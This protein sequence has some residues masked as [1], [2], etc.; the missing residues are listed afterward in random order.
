MLPN[1]TYETLSSSAV[2]V[3]SAKVTLWPAEAFDCALCS[4]SAA[5][6]LEEAAMRSQ[7][8]SM[9]A[10]RRATST[11]SPAFEHSPE[12][13]STPAASSCQWLNAPLCQ[14]PT[15]RRVVLAGSETEMVSIRPER[16]RAHTPPRLTSTFATFPPTQSW[17]NVQTSVTARARRG[18]QRIAT[19]SEG[20]EGMS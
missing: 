12:L 4:S 5:N 18:C 16:L 8:A 7:K 11:C 19:E 10:F 1:D 20:S 9:S 15:Y 6:F 14:V 17:A 13:K 3:S 2:G